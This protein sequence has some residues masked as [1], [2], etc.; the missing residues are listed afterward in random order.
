MT[1][2]IFTTGATITNLGTMTLSGS[3]IAGAFDNQGTVTVL[4]GTASSITGAVT[5]AT[6][7]MLRLNGNTSNDANLTVTTGFTNNGLAQRNQRAGDTDITGG[8]MI[9]DQAKTQVPRH[10]RHD[11]ALG[12]DSMRLVKSAPVRVN[13]AFHKIKEFTSRPKIFIVSGP[14][15]GL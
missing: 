6:G 5:T 14:E 10:E 2:S 7:S 3:T 11:A 15:V 1:G 4:G 9:A 13:V 8:L 12:P